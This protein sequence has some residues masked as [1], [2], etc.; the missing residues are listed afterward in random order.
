MTAQTTRATSTLERIAAELEDTAAAL[1]AVLDGTA[2]D[3]HLHTI[4]AH[5]TS[6]RY[7]VT[8]GSFDDVRCPSCGAPD[9]TL[10]KGDTEEGFC[11]TCAADQSATAPAP[12][13]RK[14]GEPLPAGFT[15][16][17]PECC[18]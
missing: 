17:C 3:F 4:E 9:W 7:R 6:D 18:E 8:F 10:G 1:R 13:C 2:E 12:E 16:R 5:L 15:I 14:C 11:P